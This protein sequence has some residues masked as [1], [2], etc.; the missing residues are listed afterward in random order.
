MKK[1]SSFFILLL[2]L[3]ACNNNNNKELQGNYVSQKIKRQIVDVASTYIT[4]KFTNSHKSVEE[5]GILNI[6]NGQIRYII[7]PSKI[8]VGLIDSDAVEDATIVI[9]SFNGQD[10]VSTELLILL[11]SDNKFLIT[12]VLEGDMKVIKINNRVIYVEIPQLPPDS[13]NY[14][15]AICREVV[16]Y[17]YINGDIKKA[18]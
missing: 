3:M 11:K 15:C 5:G 10:I 7:D 16:K 14:N 1:N 17:K 8:A 6:I 18:I 4:D 13:P 2:F 9:P 12:K